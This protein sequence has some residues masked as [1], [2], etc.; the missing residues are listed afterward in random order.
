[1]KHTRDE[2]LLWEVKID[3]APTNPLAWQKFNLL[4]KIFE[5][6]DY[7]EIIYQIIAKNKNADTISENDV[8]YSGKSGG[9]KSNRKRILRVR[10][11]KQHLLYI[12]RADLGQINSVDLHQKF[13]AEMAKYRMND[14]KDVEIIF[15]F[16]HP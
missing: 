5:D 1:M 9:G 7:F 11:P 13:Y 16:V 6:E 2:K 4:T 10:R 15:A 12:I 14:N 3:E 8:K